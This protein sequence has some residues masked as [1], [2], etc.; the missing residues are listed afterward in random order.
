MADKSHEREC[1]DRVI[2]CKNVSG[3]Y[4]KKLHNILKLNKENIIES[5]RPDS[6]IKLEDGAIGIE[7]YQVDVLFKTKRTSHKRNVFNRRYN[8]YNSKYGFF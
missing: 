2:K 1:F 3:D 8:A 7:H 6:I 5:E 4:A